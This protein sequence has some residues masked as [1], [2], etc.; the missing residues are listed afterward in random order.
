MFFVERVLRLSELQEVDDQLSTL[1][2]GRIAHELLERFHRAHEDDLPVF[3]DGETL[4][5]YE[6]I[7]EETFTQY[8]E[9]GERLGVPA[10]WAVT[11]R[12][13]RDCVRSY[14]EWELD[15]L[16]ETGEVPHRIEHEFGVHAPV[17]IHGTNLK[18][19]QVSL[20]IRGRIDRLD[21]DGDGDQV[22]YH[23][24]DYKLGTIPKMAGYQDGSVLQG[25]LYLR[26]I[27]ESG[28]SAG[29][30]RYRPITKPGDPKNGAQIKVG[31]AAFERALEIAFSIPA[32]VRAGFFE[33][34][35]A[36]NAHGW[37]P[38][39]PG[40]DICRSQA[41]LRVGNRFDG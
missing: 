28:L 9:M 35:L 11:Q 38:F 21:S 33:A 23:V 17:V 5:T 27:E 34:S 10:L 26:A 19:D 36:A 15:Y 7:A 3:L 40:R 2:F 1:T 14:I 12:S 41:K 22:R 39:Y 24:L 20:Q 37:P 30:C 16:D 13:V 29:K 31:S 8:E 18:G 32:R 6:R 25:P 4:E